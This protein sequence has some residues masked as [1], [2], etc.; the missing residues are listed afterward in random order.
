MTSLVAVVGAT[1]AAYLVFVM[2]RLGVHQRLPL[3]TGRLSLELIPDRAAK[4][5]GDQPLFSVD[6]PTEWLVPALADRYPDTTRWTALR[7][8]S[9]AGYIAA[10]MR[11]LGVHHGD[12]VA[13]FKRNHFDVHLMIVGVVRS[14]GIACPMNGRF[15]TQQVR[16][17]L[18]Q[19]GARVLITD[20]P[21]LARVAAEG[22]SLGDIATVVVA[23]N[24]ME[25]EPDQRAV[26]TWLRDSHPD[27]RVV[28]LQ[29]ALT[30][31]TREMAA[32]RRG[33]EEV[34]YLVHTSGTTGFP[35]AV[36]LTNGGQSHAV[37]GWLSYVHLSRSRDRG[38]L[39]VPNNHQAVILSF[40]SALLLGLPIH[41]T[42]ACA[43]EDFD[44]N[45]IA[46][47]LASGG[48]TGFFAFPIAYTMLKEIDW[49][50]HDVRAMRF[51]ASTADASHAAIERTFVE[52]G[53]AF[54]S[55][56]LPLR[57][58]VYL[59]AQG[60]SEVGTP[61][62]LRYVT[63]YTRAFDRRIGRPGSAPFGPRVRIVTPRGE[64][65]RRGDV[66]RLEAKGRTVFAGYWND[67]AMTCAAMRDGWFFTGDVA[68]QAEDGHIIQLDREV[69]VIHTDRGL[70]YSLLIEE[71]LHR[72][73][74]VFD[75]CVYGAR[76]HDGTQKPAAAVALRDGFRFDEPQLRAEL[77]SLLDPS[78]QLASVSVLAWA[79]FP[80]GITGKTL[81]RV[82]RDRTEPHPVPEANQ[83]DGFSRRSSLG[84]VISRAPRSNVK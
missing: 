27:V 57:G 80:I 48:F 61:S 32:L 17:Y 42:S 84:S 58:S 24:R 3:A 74:A 60:S 38:L 65:V 59:D 14:G 82:F 54:T 47:K 30:R 52:L 75:L 56:G 5:Y 10:L 25:V 49:T 46:G 55:V 72:H 23:A 76:Q 45:A 20:V 44:A 22:G 31:V 39:A 77:N 78:D 73:P 83:P 33:P 2:I 79:D 12:R 28:W 1:L 35:K 41:W 62:V 43:R 53:G 37:R 69:D 70:V 15:P 21:T 71:R 7:I 19:I 13:I 50:T 67:L 4:K 9:T 11:D 16:P 68:R 6:H 66:G 64:P 8:K 26:R 36:M 18:D 81:K 29:D 63:A 34:L 51:W 40:N